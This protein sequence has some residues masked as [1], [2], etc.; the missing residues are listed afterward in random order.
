MINPLLFSSKCL[1]LTFQLAPVLV[2]ILKLISYAHQQLL[3]DVAGGCL[4]EPSDPLPPD[5]SESK[6]H[7]HK[8]FI[9][10]PI[11]CL[12]LKSY[13]RVLRCSLLGQASSL[14]TL[15]Q[16]LPHIITKHGRLFLPNPAIWTLRSLSPLKQNS[17]PWRKRELSAILI[18]HGVFPCSW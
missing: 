5:E 6:P 15:P 16:H 1:N 18:H 9:S 17:L 11:C 3:F 8:I 12:L 2:S 14:R 4:F 10:E 7:N 13:A